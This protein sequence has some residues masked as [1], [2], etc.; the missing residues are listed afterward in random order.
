M[1]LT[2]AGFE[3]KRLSELKT[4][5]DAKFTEALGPINTQPD[6]VVGEVIGIFSA[7]MDDLWEALQDNYDSMYPYSA[8]GTSLDGA[9]SFVGLERLKAT[10]TTVV[11]M[12]YG[13]E[14]TLI[15]SQSL[16]RSIDNIQYITTSDTVLSRSA[17]GDVEIS[18]NTVTDNANY[19]LIVGGVSVVYT[20][21]SDTS[22]Q[23]I[24]NGL[25]LLI[26]DSKYLA[27]AE[28]GILR[29]RSVDLYS[30]FTLTYDSKLTIDKLGT[31]VVFTCLELGANSLPVGS[32]NRIDS[33]IFGWNEINN[34][35][36]GDTG[37]NVESDEE[38][39]V[40]H[41][42]LRSVAGSATVNA[43]RSRLAQEVDSISSA[44][45]YENRTNQINSFSMPPHSV[46]CVVVGG[47]NQ[48]IANK[49]FEV[50]PAG[51][52]TY[53]NIST[54]VLDENGDLQIV[55]FSRATSSYAWVRV[56]IDAL[57]P[58][59]S[60][61]L[62]IQNAIK[63]AVM[64]YGSTIGI[65]EDII[66]QRFYGPIYQSTSGLGSITVEVA[67]TEN[68][69]DTPSYSTSNIPVSRTQSVAFDELRISVVGV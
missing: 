15:P 18:V 66:V 62:S 21:D 5:F 6:S 45:V 30:D 53:G 46:E 61:T 69:T 3:R 43:I 68:P 14:S 54:E 44:S 41:A 13:D 27:T 55:K 28:N 36:A 56:S 20:A 57:Y 39:R 19:Q 33:S 34:L 24:A 8:E 38:L 35:V 50:K 23:E 17:C 2:T 49:I 51:I 67:L 60:L 25:A 9:V 40:R 58:E 1:T 59:E 11:A 64:S 12:C 47:S 32:L 26:D 29:I 7:A 37:R 42:N 48:E 22:D 16:A 10:A 65:G 4:E 63:T 52:E 31:P